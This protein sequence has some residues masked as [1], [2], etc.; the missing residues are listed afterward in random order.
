MSR[1]KF[2]ERVDEFSELYDLPLNMMQAAERLTALKLQE[3]LTNDE[4]NELT[5]LSAELAEFM[6]TPELFNTF[7]DSLTAT[8][9]FFRDNVQG[10]LEQKQTVWNNYIN[11]LKHAGVWA[12]GKAYKLHNFVSDA[13]GDLF[14]CLRDHTSNSTN[15][16]TNTTYWR[17][18]SQKG[19][20]GDIG[21][22]A[23]Y[24][25]DWNATTAYAIGDAVSFNRVGW[26][27][28]IVY[29]AK[30]ANTGKSPDAST[31]DWMMYQEVTFGTVRPT[32]AQS[33]MHFI[34]EL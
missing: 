3:R 23:F 13:T 6:I 18:L 28:P 34:K 10:Y 14:I 7:G 9:L 19:D 15:G 25:G 33:G 8:Q 31:T 29:I 11:Q 30:T 17:R 22:N 26:Q 20:T 2:P 12:T 5:S 4:Q 27:K 1:S 24:R 32:G 16:L 21:L